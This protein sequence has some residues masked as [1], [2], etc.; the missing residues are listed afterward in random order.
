MK[1]FGCKENKLSNEFPQFDI[2][3]NCKHPRFHCMRCV[4][5]EVK[6]E[7]RCPYAECGTPVTSENRNIAIMQRTLDEMFREYTTEFTPLVIPEGGSQGVVRVAVLNGDSMTVNY[8]PSM[9]VLELKQAIQNKLKHDVQKQKL[10]YNDKEIKVYGDGQKP[11]KLSDYNIQP[12][13]TVYLVVLMFA[14]PE[15]FDHVVFDLYWGFPVS[16]VDYL[17]ASC[18]LYN[19]TQF[20][21]LCDYRHL[22]CVTGAVKHS[23]DILDRIKNQGHHVINVYLKKIPSN[24]THLFF[25]LSA[26]NSPNISKYPNPSL[27]FYEA[28]K[29]HTDLCK[30]SFTHA[31]HSEAVIMCS[32]SR[33]GGQWAIYE[34]G[35]LSTGNARHYDPIKGSIQTLISQGY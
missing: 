33:S 19:G 1:C 7:K 17:D 22:S 35:K 23:G 14:I 18:L 24:V 12:S 10:L 28:D 20:L 8:R 26:W 13:S 16:G 15:G 32:V 21:H 27:K 3:K 30:T 2:T 34:S 9:T 29:P 31:N 11:M 5:R 25:T 4:I 6:E